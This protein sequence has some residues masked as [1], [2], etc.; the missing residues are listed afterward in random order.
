MRPK[1][2]AVDHEQNLFVTDAGF[3]NVQIFNKANQLLLFL[4]HRIPDPEYH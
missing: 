2:L 4:K 3:E 1:G